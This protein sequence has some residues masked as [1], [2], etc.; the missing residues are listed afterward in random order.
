MNNQGMKKTGA[1]SVADAVEIATPRM[2]H[3]ARIIELCLSVGLR[4]LALNIAFSTD[5]SKL[6]DAGRVK[7][8]TVTLFIS[9][10]V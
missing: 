3:G 10:P 8:G 1:G 2:G 4:L 7:F 5:W 6:I 9:N